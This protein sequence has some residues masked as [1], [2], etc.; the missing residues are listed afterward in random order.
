MSK[1]GIICLG[2][3]MKNWSKLDYIMLGGFLISL[4]VFIIGVVNSVVTYQMN[5]FKYF[6]YF[7][8]QTNLFVVLYFALYKTKIMNTL[9]TPIMLLITVTMLVYN[10]LLRGLM[11]NPNTL[12]VVADNG[13]HVLVPLLMIIAW[14][15]TRKTSSESYLNIA[16]MSGYGMGYCIF[17]LVLANVTDFGFPYF[18]L[19]YPKNGVGYVAIYVI[20]LLAIFNILAF[21]VTYIEKKYKKAI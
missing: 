15:I 13:L 20:S 3:I 8:V 7:T 14:V 16:I 1:Y 6:S 21:L 2:D 10:I 5:T 9:R 18:F 17:A 19:D 11:N 4:T 12:A